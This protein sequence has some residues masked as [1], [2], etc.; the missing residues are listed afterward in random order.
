MTRPFTLYALGCIAM[1]IAVGCFIK[2]PAVMLTIGAIAVAGIVIS[3]F[4]LVAVLI[5]IYFVMGPGAAR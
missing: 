5:V 1:A 4:G 3:G 2:W